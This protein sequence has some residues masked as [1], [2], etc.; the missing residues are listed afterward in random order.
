MTFDKQSNVRRTPVESKSSRSRIVVVTI[1][2]II[3]I[4]IKELI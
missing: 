2:I 4:I 1:I 3:I